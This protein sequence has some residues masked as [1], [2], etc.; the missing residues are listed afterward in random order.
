MARKSPRATTASLAERHRHDRWLMLIAI[1][2]FAQ[3]LVFIMIG[4]GAHRL[5]HK[6]I[7]DEIETFARHLR[8]NPES[9]LVNFILDK[10]SLVND[11]LLRRIG[12]AAFGYAGLCI[13]EGLGLYL[14]K[15]WGEFL[16]L[17]ITASFLPWEL[18]E[19]FRHI[20]WIKVGL[21]SIN[22]LVFL[23]LLKLVAEKARQRMKSRNKH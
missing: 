4:L 8:F 14:E 21:F 23:Y 19:I 6:D 7:A 10:A 18:Y 17:A 2:K 3:A 9:R 5:L 20:T 15:A 12:F 13:A 16:T 11:P 22:I 1:F